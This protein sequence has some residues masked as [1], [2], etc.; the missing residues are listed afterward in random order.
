MATRAARS[1]RGGG[2][3]RRGTAS[4]QGF[5]HLVRDRHPPGL[6]SQTEVELLLQ[7]GRVDMVF[8]R[9]PGE[10]PRHDEARVMR[11]LWHR[12]SRITLLEFKGP[13]RGYRSSDLLRLEN[14][15]GL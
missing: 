10:L 8:E 15:A 9:R 13:T 6:M 1:S 14:Y 5:A 11:G 12:L 7:P 4:H 3:Q 2:N